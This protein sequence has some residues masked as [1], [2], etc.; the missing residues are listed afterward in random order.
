[1]GPDAV[2]VCPRDFLAALKP[3]L[4][5]RQGQGHRIALITRTHNAEEIRQQIRRVAR[6]GQLQYVMLVGDA[7]ED[8][9]PRR[10]VPTHFAEADVTLRWGSEPRISTDNWYADLD[11]DQLP[12]VAVGRL[13]ADTTDELAVLV[14]KTLAY[15]T[16]ANVG[17]WRRRVNFIAGVGGFGPIADAV[18][19]TVAKRFITEGVPSEYDTSMTYASWRSP[20]SP[21][22]RRFQQR[23]IERFNEGCLAWVYLGHGTARDL[24]RVRVPGAEL[25]IFS[26]DNAAQLAWRHGAPIAVFLSCHA[27][28]FDYPQDCLAEEVLRCPSGPVAVVCGSRLTMPY[29]M[30]V[31][32]NALLEELFAVAI[33]RFCTINVTKMKLLYQ[34]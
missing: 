14:R 26:A 1:L 31:L 10:G 11:D 18:V 32:G 33:Q 21:D 30:A 19:E 34:S 24:D 29:A 2:V 6:S 17:L 23:T 22:P 20:Y 3:W 12:D 13:T 4:A 25:S 15:E 9:H 28:A 7:P 5:H 8:Q 27:G 16:N